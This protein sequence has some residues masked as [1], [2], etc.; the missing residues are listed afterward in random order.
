VRGWTRT[1]SAATLMTY[2][3]RLGSRK[4]R[5]DPVCRSSMTG[6]VCDSGLA[7]RLL[8]MASSIGS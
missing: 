4:G 7:G 2:T 6:W 1:S 5:A 8:L 3:G